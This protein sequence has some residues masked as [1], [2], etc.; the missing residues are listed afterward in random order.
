MRKQDKRVPFLAA[1]AFL[2]ALVSRSPVADAQTQP[3]AAGEKLRLAVDVGPLGVTRHSQVPLL[4]T[5]DILGNGPYDLL[6]SNRTF[7]PFEHFTAGGVPVYGQPREFQAPPGSLALITGD[8]K[9]S[10]VV[11]RDN[12]VRMAQFDRSNLRFEFSDPRSVE[13]PGGLKTLTATSLTNNRIAVLFTK[14]DGKAHGVPGAHS[15]S[16][17][18]RPFNGSGI[19][20]GKLSYAVLGALKL[21]MD[22]PAAEVSFPIFPSQRDF[23]IR[24]TGLSQVEF[25]AHEQRGVMGAASQGMFYYFRNST[26]NGLELEPAV[27]MCGADS[28]G[29]RHPGIYPSPAAIPDPTTGDSD[30][31]V[32]DTSAVWFYNFS[33]RFSSRGGPIYDPPVPVLIKDPALMIG[34]LPVLTSGDL[35]GDRLTD[36]LSGN[37]AGHF[38]FIRNIGTAEQA[39]F[40]APQRINAGGKVVKVDAGYTGIQGPSESRWGYTCPTLVDWNH[41]GLLD[42]VYNSIQADISVML[43]EPGS[44]P[45]AFAP[46]VVLKSDTMELHLVWRTQPAITNWGVADGPQCII[47]NDEQNQLRRYWQV[48]DYNVTPGEVLRL[49]TGEPIQAHG[50]RFAGQFGRTKLQAVD[51][52]GDSVI[53]LL[54]GTGRAA[55]LPGPGGIPDDTFEGERRQASVLFLRNAGTN[56]E[57][58]FEYPRVMTFNGDKLEMGTHSCSP[59]AVDLGRGQL[60]LLVGEEHGSV[61]Y[62][63]REKLATVSVGSADASPAVESIPND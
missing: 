62:Y 57:P 23:L 55:S 52:D 26:Q 13:V 58:V 38:F 16:A 48:D 37:D 43:H 28:N 3:W 35:D 51:W 59:L 54:A 25:P 56:S 60:D 36:L 4:G 44:N 12:K 50:K 42:I 5:A 22:T 32:A 21:G 11:Y 19:W 29:M 20:R 41:D 6:V 9:L 30:L 24:C 31:L 7:L 61:I 34:A 15:H 8:E 14:G 53:D 10:A 49:T 39:E 1:C 46:P 47:V 33:G 45:P 63:P 40:A 2:V 17:E 27:L 18:Y